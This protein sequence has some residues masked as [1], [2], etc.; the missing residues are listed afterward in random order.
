MQICHSP[1]TKVILAL[2]GGSIACTI[3]RT[4]TT[5]V[6]AF[7]H[8]TLSILRVSAYRGFLVVCITGYLII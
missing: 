2:G 3:G 6:G 4:V 1:D 5:T 7:V 8:C